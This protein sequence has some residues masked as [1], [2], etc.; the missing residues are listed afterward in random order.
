MEAIASSLIT[1]LRPELRHHLSLWMTSTLNEKI[2]GTRD[3]QPN[4]LVVQLQRRSIKLLNQKQQK[5]HYC[6][7]LTELIYLTR[8]FYS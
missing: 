7:A 8:F 4:H 5:Q 1:R 2:S 3:R 6:W